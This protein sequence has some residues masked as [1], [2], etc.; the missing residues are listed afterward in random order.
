MSI[1]GYIEDVRTFL[2]RQ[3]L[4]RFALWISIFGSLIFFTIIQLESIFYLLPREKVSF[5]LSMITI[6]IFM[7]VFCA[8]YYSQAK[9]NRVTKYTVENLARSLGDKIFPEK[10]DL[11]L[12]ALQL[13]TK[14]E[15]NE[16][17]VLAIS[18]IKN[19]Q[20]KLVNVDLNESFFNAKLPKLKYGLLSVWVCILIIFFFNYDSAADAFFRLTNPNEIFPAPKPFTLLSMSGDIHIIGGE[21][22]DIYVQA[23]PLVPD[24]LH[25]NLI[26]IQASN[27]KRDSLSLHFKTTAIEDGVFH[28]KLPEL[29]QDYSYQA[30]ARA[31]Y[32]WEAWEKVSSN[33]DTIFVTDRPAFDNFTLTT[34]PPPY[35]K[36][37]RRTQKGNIAMV[38][39]L[40]GSI[41][42]IDLA[43]NR[44]L[45][46]SYID[47]NGERSEMSSSY[48]KASGYFTLMDEGEFTVNLVDKRGITNRDPVPYK[49][50]MIPDHDPNIS[51]ITPPK[52]TELGNDQTIPIHLEINDDFG[53]SNLQLA[54]EIQRPAYLQADP[55]VAMFNINGLHVDSLNQ[56]IEMYWD[57]TDM[58]LMPD[59][60]V[61]FHFEL[62]DNDDISGPKKTITNTFIAQVPSLADLYE[63]IDNSEE[64]L[65]DEIVNGL[66]EL[67]DIKNQFEATELQML[68][69][70]ELD[71]DEQQSLKNSLEQS[72]KEIENL[73]KMAEA[74]ASITE[75]AEKHKLLSPG[76]L[77]KFKDIQFLYII[78]ILELI[79]DM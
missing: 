13:E 9:K 47:I 23:Y 66:D 39:G 51:V 44:M 30:F 36:R 31:K 11:V 65:I 7:I 3:A 45:Q 62:T 75:Q 46:T 50:N 20:N 34:I 49:I 25:L 57:L 18:Y 69:N 78:K 63:S 61:H 4:S 1:A 59:D 24:T 21:E 2:L 72:K 41:I 56:K 28:F 77:E 8:L 6:F 68:K 76:L 14:T 37:E 40:K 42:Q 73:E 15:K 33:T 71:W 55:Y 67:G 27:Q 38:E 12:N 19:I 26:P 32:F 79:L 22:A 60:E 70:N 74:I 29:F 52:M 35:S 64:E 17:E 5:L 16:S 43:S 58:M 10:C 48:N 54:Y 53:F